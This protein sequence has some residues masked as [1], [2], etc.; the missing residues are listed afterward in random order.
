MPSS[1]ARASS[2][3]PEPRD[4]PRN[5][6]RAA[7]SSHGV[8]SPCSAGTKRT[9]PLDA[10]DAA[11][12]ETSAAIARDAELDQP[13]DRAA[14]GE[15]R[16][17]EAERARAVAERPERERVGA[18]RGLRERLA[19]VYVEHGR[20]AERELRVAARV[21]A[22]REGGGLL[23]AGARR[24]R[25][26]RAEQ[27][28]AGRADRR[29][30]RHELRAAPR[31]ARRT[32]RAAPA[33]TRPWR[34]RRARCTTR[35][36]DR[37]RARR[38]R[39]AAPRATRR[40]CRAASVP[41]RAAS[42]T[43]SSCCSHHSNFV[44]DACVVI[45]TPSARSPA[46]R[47]ALRWSCQTCAGASGRRLRASQHSA[48]ARCVT[49]PSPATSRASAR[50]LASA[51]RSTSRRALDQRVGILLDPA[52]PRVARLERRL[53]A[54]DAPGPSG[55]TASARTLVVPRS[56]ASSSSRLTAR[57]GSSTP[58]IQEIVRV[59]AALQRAQQRD[60]GVAELGAQVR[61]AHPADAVVVR[62][63]AARRDRRL[64]GAPPALGVDL[65]H[66]RAVFDPRREREVQVRAGAVRVTRVRAREHHLGHLAQ[67]G[68]DRVVERQHAR[69]GR[70][71]LDRV[72]HEPALVQLAEARHLVAVREPVLDRAR[73]GARAALA[74][75]TAPRRPRPRRRPRPSGLR[76]RA[77]AC[78]GSRGVSAANRR[79]DSR[80]S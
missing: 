22:L 18:G 26:R 53:L 52:R 75:R 33:P 76:A 77:A 61:A 64:H 50:A 25:N 56:S 70:G 14:R 57:S 7:S 42:R 65:G 3:L 20:G 74:P 8:P 80:S 66:A 67:R 48:L 10:A 27:I 16:P 55:A 68:G 21:R 12:R 5:A 38:R 44:A 41:A 71:D 62:D 49:T 51:A 63:A 1:T 78:S 79:R 59:E 40:A 73:V 23:I 54:R 72:D 29:A 43:A 60:A 58:G 39:R 13:V 36:R 24:E 37:S 46:T 17:L 34:R 35:C 19:R 11:R 9:P 32:G 47:S 15:H 31:A 6:P 2:A 45:G 30:G 69:P 28:G 4:R